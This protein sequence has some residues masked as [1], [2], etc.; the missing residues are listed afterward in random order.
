MEYDN[1]G[2]ISRPRTRKSIRLR[3]TLRAKPDTHPD[4]V[5]TSADPPIA[6]TRFQRTLS[7]KEFQASESL[8][9]AETCPR[10]RRSDAR[11][12]IES[13]LRHV[14][15]A[16]KDR[17]M[18]AKTK[19][20]RFKSEAQERKFWEAHGSAELID[21]SK[22]KR[23]RLPNLKPSTQSISLRLPVHTLERIRLRRTHGTCPINP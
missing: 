12:Q 19:V 2:E 17:S 3:R 9:E 14:Q 23:A 1:I 5:F 13:G 8:L 7:Q 6:F 15:S 16:R 10:Q 11:C 18:N 20:L 22:F 4:V 21:W